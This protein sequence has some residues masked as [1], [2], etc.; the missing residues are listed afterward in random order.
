MSSSTRPSRAGLEVV[1]GRHPA[2]NVL[3]GSGDVGLVGVRPAEVRRRR[4]SSTSTERGISGHSASP[5]RSGFTACQTSTNGWPTISTCAPIG[6]RATSSAIRLSL[7]PAHEVV[8]EHPDP[9]VLRGPEVAQV[10]GQVVDAAEVLHDHALDPQVVAPDLLDELGVVPA[11]DVDPA[12]PRD[13]RP[14]VGDRDRAGCGAGGLRRR[15]PADGALRI[16]GLP[17]SRNPGP[18]GK[19]RRRPRRSSSVSVPRSRSTA[20]ISPHQSVV[21]SSTTT[22]SSAARLDGT[23]ALRGA[24]VGRE[25]V[26]PVAVEPCR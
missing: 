11:L 18:S 8:D 12:G 10:A 19:V 1:V 26:G 2:E 22:P 6:D 7:E 14:R 24:P 20:T 9:A 5:S 25:D 21:T 3:P 13:P 16:T 17:S 15:C 4:P 23:S